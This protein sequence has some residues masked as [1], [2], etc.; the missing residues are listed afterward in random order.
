MSALLLV[1]SG[2]VLFVLAYVGYGGFIARRLGIDGGRPTPAETMNDG[3]DYVPTK[4][5]VVLG[6]HFASIAGA[7]PIV[8]PVMASIFGW[9]PVYLW[10][11]VGGIFVGAVHDF[12]SLVASLRHRGK[13]IGEVIEEHIGRNGKVLFLLFSWS[14][15]ILVIAVFTQLVAKTFE[16]VPSSATASVLF[17]V[18][19]IGFGVGVYRQRLPLVLATVGG[20]LLL[21]ACIYVGQRWPLFLPAATWR[22]LLLAYC[23]AAAV[24]PVWFLLQPR[25]YLNSFLLY[26]LLLGGAVGLVFARPQVQLAP[27]TRFHTDL[28]YLFPVLFVTV[29]CGAISGFHSLVASGTTAKQVAKER[30]AKPI[31]YG[32]MLIE[33]LLAIVALLTAATMASGRLHE[34]YAG[35]SFVQIFVEGV[36]HFM[37]R[38]PVLGLK[39]EAATIFAALGVSAFVLTSLDTSTRLARFAFQEFFESGRRGGKASWVT[40]RYLATALTVV[41]AW[42]FLISGG[43][44][45]IWPVFGSANQLLAALAMLAVSVWLAKRGTPNSFVRYPMFFMFLVTLTALASLVYKNFTRG[46]YLLVVIGVV[47]FCLA[48][49]LISQAVRSLRAATRKAT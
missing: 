35:K 15:L 28:G 43:S 24:L 17:M 19:A 18:L 5:P 8:G 6:H 38:I 33:S 9:L 39:E 10:I 12:S 14:T 20:V 11:V 44:D 3:V 1:L 37:A 16:Q 22:Y 36:G 7:G 21:F 23:F 48:G 45:A 25:D 34:L 47:L 27:I 40:N 31:G 29:A 41:A 46:N 49:L 42:I 26:A 2:M 32:A 30:D 13:S 4:A